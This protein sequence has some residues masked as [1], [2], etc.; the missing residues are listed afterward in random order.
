MASDPMSLP[1]RLTEVRVGQD[2][3]AIA[4]ALGK[5]PGPAL[6][7]DRST[8]CTAFENLRPSAIDLHP[9]GPSLL[10]LRSSSLRD[11]IATLR[12]SPMGFA[13]A[14]PRRLVARLTVANLPLRLIHS[15]RRDP[16]FSS[17]PH[18]AS[19]SDV[20]SVPVT[21]CTIREVD[22]F[23]TPLA[24]RSMW[25]RDPPLARD[26]TPCAMEAAA[27]GDLR[28]VWERMSDFRVVLE[29][30]S[31][32]MTTAEDAWSSLPEKSSFSVRSA[33]MS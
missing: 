29:L 19:P 25:V 3:I 2:L 28:E 15:A 22:S 4:K 30:R 7:A 13:P 31:A 11:R 6:L 17:R 33:P 23:A 1:R 9:S 5:G 14:A 20:R 21:A 10:L 16:C 27:A 8:D 32:P 12:A 24:P 26:S 18:L